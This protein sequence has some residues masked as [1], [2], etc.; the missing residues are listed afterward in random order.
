MTMPTTANRGVLARILETGMVEGPN[1]EQIEVHSQVSPGE[2]EFLQSVIRHVRPKRSIEVGLA[3][4]LSTL[5][6]CEALVEV[7]AER[8][9]AVDP[10]QFAV[11]PEE[12]RHYTSFTGWKG[13]GLANVKRAG[14]GDLVEH[15]AER[16]DVALPR[17]AA[18]GTKFDFAFIDGYHTFEAAFIDFYYIDQMINVGGVIAFDDLT[19]PAVCK[20]VRFAIQNRDYSPILTTPEPSAKSWKLK[21]A[22]SILGS[23]LRPDVVTPNAELGITRQWIALRKNSALPNG[24]MPGARRWDAHVDF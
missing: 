2:G 8:H 4:G 13:V 23:K 5:Y 21:L 1:G 6:M 18:S 15:I 14:Y 3:Y 11:P 16:S 7:G 22:E 24:D 17:L 12:G 9:V 20:A 19:Y 10:Y